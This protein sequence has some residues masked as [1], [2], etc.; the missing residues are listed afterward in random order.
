MIRII[1]LFI[2]AYIA[3][4]VNIAV[5]L[6]KIFR[7]DDPRTKF[8]GNAGTV[9]IYRQSGIFWAATV[10]ILD[11]GRAIAVSVISFRLLAPGLAPIAGLALILGNRFPCFHGFRGGKGVANYLGFTAVI[12]PLLTAAAAVLWVIVYGAVRLPF[13]ASFFMVFLLAFANIYSHN[14]AVISTVFTLLTVFLI[15]FNHKKNI[16]DLLNIHV[17]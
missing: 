13:I 2:A 11:F 5:L 8:S 9:N 10:F 16:F 15:I 12:S 4:S 17:K 14:Y 7:K 6:F 1:I 3:G